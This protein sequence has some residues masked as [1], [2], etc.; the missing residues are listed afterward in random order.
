MILREKDSP[1]EGKGVL[2]GPAGMQTVFSEAS[3]ELAVLTGNST[4]INDTSVQATA[5]AMLTRAKI[6]AASA[7]IPDDKVREEINSWLNKELGE[8]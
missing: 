4:S 1:P 7:N 2:Y 3:V 5:E 6:T 8:D